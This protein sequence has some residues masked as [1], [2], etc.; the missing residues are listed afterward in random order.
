MRSFGI[1]FVIAILALIILLANSLYIVTDKQTAILL[2]FGEIIDPK[3]ESGLH[4]KVPI[5]NTVRKFDSRVLTLDAIPQPYF[6]EE[7]KRLIVD[8]FVKWRISDNEQFYITSSGGQLS[9]LR[10]LL[11]QRVDEG[12]RNQF[13]KR[14]VQ[15]VISGERDQLMRVLTADLNKVANSE[16]GVEVIDVRVKKIELPTEVNDSV[17]NRMRT[18]RE[19]LAQEL[20][21][22]GNEIAEEIRANADK[23]RTVILAD[24]YKTAE[25]IKGEGDAEATSTYAKAFN[26]NPE[27]YEFTRSLSAYQSTFENKSDVLLIDPESDFFKYLD[28]SFGTS[29]SE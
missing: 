11:T 3:I 8:A 18:E 12:L 13:G 24:A 29:K 1:G 2:R 14:T 20:R 10:T 6:T 4:F 16:L 17:Y 19:R 27:F 22:E 15:D 9:A 23:E 26:K 25:I 21:A 5:L 7:K 28:S